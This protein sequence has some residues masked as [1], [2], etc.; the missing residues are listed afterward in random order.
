LYRRF[1]RFA[2]GQAFHLLALLDHS[3]ERGAIRGVV[4]D[5]Q[6]GYG[7]IFHDQLRCEGN[8]RMKI[9]HEH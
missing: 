9:F 1:A 5:Q 3:R 6:D 4:F 8:V 7:F 2:G